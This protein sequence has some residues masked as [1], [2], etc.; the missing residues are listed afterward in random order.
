MHI[1]VTGQG[2]E[3]Q[4]PD[5]FFDADLAGL[6][7]EYGRDIAVARGVIFFLGV[8]AEDL[9]EIFRVNWAVR[10]AVKALDR[11]GLSYEIADPLRQVCDRI[12][13]DELNLRYIDADQSRQGKER[14]LVLGYALKSQGGQFDDP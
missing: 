5:E 14:I 7:S 6:R 3:G 10:C 13:I 11:K 8:D 12:D 9:R 1:G 4:T 2:A